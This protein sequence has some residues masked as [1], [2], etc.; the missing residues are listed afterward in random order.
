[1]TPRLSRRRLLGLGA[2]LATAA[3]VGCTSGD[4]EEPATDPTVN[5]ATE[6]E[7]VP[8]VR[9]RPVSGAP[10]S[11]GTGGGI[12]LGV[13]A[14]EVGD[15]GLDSISRAL[16]YSRLVGVD[17]RSAAVFGDLAVEI[18]LP[19]PLLVRFRLREDR[20]FHPDASGQA[21]PVTADEI[22]RDFEA[23]RDEG[24]FLFTDVIERAEAPDPRELLLRL[25]APFSLLFEYL[26]RTDASVRGRGD[27]GVVPA[28]LGSGRFLPS[29][30][31]GDGLELRSNP[32]VP[33]DE[34]PRLEQVL[35][36]HGVQ[37]GDLDELFMRGLLDVRE[38]PDSQSRQVASARLDRAEQA[39][40]RHRLRGLALSLLP[41][42]DEASQRTVDAFRDARVREA[43]SLAV[44]R[45]ALGFTDGALTAGPIGPAFGG[46]A[47]PQ[48]E[49]EAH[50]LYQHDPA[51]ARQLLTAAGHQDLAF[52]L[53]H[54]SSPLMT[55][56]AQQFVEQLAAAGIT[57]R[58][59]GRPQTEF[60]SAFLGGDFEAALFEL[61]RLES[62][63]LGL[64]LHTTGGLD[65]QGSP[66]GYS[67]PVYDSRV[68]DALSQIDPALR[69]RHAREAQRLLL[70]D[71]PAMLPLVTPLEYASVSL[72]VEGYEFDGYDFNNGS[73]AHRWQVTP[74]GGG[75]TT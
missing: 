8:R 53:S 63:D 73:L 44:N 60:Q 29:R 27:Y 19:E 36:R 11:G 21:F 2:G 47:L 38:H 50:R 75:G 42:R 26:A 67:N 31:D 72:G 37:D 30:L 70:E 64:R 24:V 71:V 43:C 14:A 1:M 69:T 7:Q 10:A 65:G 17:P 51:R 6:P 16:S 5:T 46:D 57:V 59:V 18:E 12:V 40:P 49:L 20:L 45:T 61:D 28:A 68:R 35:V 22:V 25:R 54:A 3:L 74:P 55:G 33:P 4:S 9:V 48:V 58:L 39:R 41:A 15:D 13:A 56:L 62:P 32:L 23:R 34:R 52:R 66:W